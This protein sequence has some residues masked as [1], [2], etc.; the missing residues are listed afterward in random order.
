MPM[1]VVLRLALGLLLAVPCG[2]AGAAEAFRDCSQCPEMVM[3]PAGFAIGR[4]E[5]T[6]DEWQACVA[7]GACRGDLDD[8]GWGRGRRPVINITWAD[9]VGYARWLSGLTGRAYALPT[10]E[11]WEYAARAGTTT[12]YWW[13]DGVG[14]GNAN[15]RQCGGAWD[16]V[17]TAPVGSFAANPFDLYDMNGNVWEWTAD[18]W[19][20]DCSR[21]A[22]RGGA[23]YYFGQMSK[24]S[25]RSGMEARQWSYT[26]GIRVIARGTPRGA[27]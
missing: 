10:E 5:V 11:E 2:A 23:W 22:I 14:Q 12:A 7:A 27:S 19:Q 24:A 8:H 21:R 26:I 6:F 9:A 4:F 13:G 25:A 18:C 15:C 3:L 1:L 20:G 17:S 16:G